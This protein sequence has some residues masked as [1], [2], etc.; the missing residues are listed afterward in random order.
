MR[1]L[2]SQPRI[3][4]TWVEEMTVALLGNLRR[5]RNKYLPTP[6]NQ[7][8]QMQDLVEARG[9]GSGVSSAALLTALVR[10]EVVQ[11]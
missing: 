11:T 7:T 3:P 9:Q 1:Y 2:C 10:G 8:I 4:C 5:S 6:D